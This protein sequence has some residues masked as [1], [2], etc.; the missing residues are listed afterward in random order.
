MMSTKPFLLHLTRLYKRTLEHK[1]HMNTDAQKEHQ[2]PRMST[3]IEAPTIKH[4]QFDGVVLR[5][6]DEH[7]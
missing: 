6:P 1:Q 5:V 2:R 3:K 7:A 4:Q